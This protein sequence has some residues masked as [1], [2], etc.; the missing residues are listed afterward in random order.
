M[1]KGTVLISHLT[2]K[3]DN[4]LWYVMAT[5]SLNKNEL[6]MDNKLIS[7]TNYL[8]PCFW[9]RANHCHFIVLNISAN[10][11]Y[12]R[13]IF[14]YYHQKNFTRN[15]QLIH[16]TK[17]VMNNSAAQCRMGHTVFTEY[18]NKWQ[19]AI[20]LLYSYSTN[21]SLINSHSSL[22]SSFT[23]RKTAYVLGRK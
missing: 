19:S 1:T 14:L 18:K 4:S 23:R 21:K 9:S 17:L 13:M 12:R 6:T 5:R 8:L 15:T 10:S 3:T 20:I 11:S 16:R 2:P 7:S 22:A